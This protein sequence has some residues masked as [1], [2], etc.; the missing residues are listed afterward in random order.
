MK[1][2]FD[3]FPLLLFFAAYKFAD[4]YVATGVAMAASVLQ[5]VWL[6]ARRRKIEP[7]HW[8]NL[9]IIVVFGGATLF[10]HDET[11]IKWKPTVLYW[12]FAA[13]LAGGQWLFRRNFLRSMLGAQIQLADTVWNRLNMAWV[14][15]F[16]A[17]GALNLY[18][19]YRWPTEIWVNFKVFGIFGLLL[20]FIVLQSIYLGRH[21][22]QPGEGKVEEIAKRETDAGAE[23]S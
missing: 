11:F 7:M 14:T 23:R 15:F 18:V 20:V 9:T 5:I 16:A 3:L 22:K 13:V 1:L 10:L 2:L 4:I 6:L 8:I 17:V 19:A 12:L 21:I